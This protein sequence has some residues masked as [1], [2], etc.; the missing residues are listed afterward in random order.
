MQVVILCGGM[1]TRLREETE[2]RPKPLV[3]IGARPMLWHIMKIY[4]H[5]GH[6]DFILCLGYKGNM[7]KEYFLNYRLINGDFTLNLTEPQKPHFHGNPQKDEE[8]TITFANTGNEAMTGARV[9]RIERYI[10]G[11]NFML[12]YGDGLANI[13]IGAL[14]E[15]HFQQKT[16]ATVTGVR[17]V[18]RYGELSTQGILVKEFNE[19]PAVQDGLVSGGFFVFQR[20]IFDYLKSDDSCV[21]EREPLERLAREGQL[22]CYPHNDFWHAMDTYRDFLVLNELWRNSAHW[23]V[24]Q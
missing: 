21:L 14:L 1:G 4:A 11:D 3:E 7:I 20:S 24:W 2:F 13:N 6:K 16:I 22:A 9:K 19:K 15:F 23:K 12:T 10:N 18:S 5:Y 8:W 17:P